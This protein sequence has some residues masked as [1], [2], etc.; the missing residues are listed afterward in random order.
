MGERMKATGLVRKLDVLRRA[1]IPIYLRRKLKIDYFNLVEIK[2][3]RDMIILT[4]YQ[5]KC[6]FCGNTVDVVEKLDRHICRNC[7]KELAKF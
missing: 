1:T 3:D 7:L 2:V 6:I 5:P 4:K